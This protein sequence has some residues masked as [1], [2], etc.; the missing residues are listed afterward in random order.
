LFSTL[1]FKILKR[2]APSGVCGNR[3]VN[4]CFVVSASA[5]AG[6]DGIGVFTKQVWVNH[7]SRLP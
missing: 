4:Q 2:L 6:L 1:G 5:L 7:P 3:L